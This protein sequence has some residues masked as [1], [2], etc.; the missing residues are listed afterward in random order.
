MTLAILL[1]SIFCFLSAPPA[2][3][4]RHGI[5]AQSPSAGTAVEGTP[6][7]DQETAPPTQNPPA[8]EPPA[9]TTTPGTT[10]EKAEKKPAGPVRSRKSRKAHRKKTPSF[11]CAST[12]SGAPSGT[13]AATG[14]NA[15]TSGSSG[16]ASTAANCPPSKVIVKQGGASETSIQLA[17]PTSGTAS[18]PAETAKQMLATTEANLKK[19][20]GQQL[21]ANQQEM[22]NQIHQFMAQSKS[23]VSDGDLERARTLAWKA[24]VLSDELVKPPSK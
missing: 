6:M 16:P 14:S 18:L 17:G 21:S 10:P 19:I 12:P 15:S 4:S 8:Q 24:Q 13:P 23:A 22:V 7:Q 5:A 2:T 1:F 11:N 20:G 9:A 3:A